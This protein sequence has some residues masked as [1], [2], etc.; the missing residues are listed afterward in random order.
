MLV[1]CRHDVLHVAIATV[2]REALLALPGPVAAGPVVEA[3]TGACGGVTQPAIV[4]GGVLS[5]SL[6]TG[7]GM[8]QRSGFVRIKGQDYEPFEPLDTSAVLEDIDH[9]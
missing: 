2:A 5:C 3:L 7:R 8:E 4:A 9:P 1:L 6:N